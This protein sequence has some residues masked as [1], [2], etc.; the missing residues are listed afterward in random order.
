MALSVEASEIVEHFQWLT[1]E[2][3]TNLPKGKLKEVEEE[4]VNEVVETSP[5]TTEVEAVESE[6]E[7]EEVETE[8]EV[9]TEEE[10]E[11]EEVEVAEMPDYASMSYPALR[12]LVSADDE[13]TL[14]DKK[15]ATFVTFLTNKW[16]AENVQ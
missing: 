8:A 3:S 14:E 5:D 2:Q 11:E 16:V 6:V 1:Q 7:T 4:I 9:E 15:G 12:K 10:A 13:K